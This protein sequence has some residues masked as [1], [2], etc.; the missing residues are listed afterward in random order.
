MTLVDEIEE[1]IDQLGGS[2]QAPEI[3]AGQAI[4]Y[5]LI[6]LAKVLEPIAA[7]AVEALE[8]DR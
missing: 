5:G 2:V 6:A 8:E 4:G 7:L 3:K 1:K